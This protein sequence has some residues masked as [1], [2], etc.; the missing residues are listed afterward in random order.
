MSLQ[1]VYANLAGPAQPWIPTR[2]VNYFRTYIAGQCLKL[3]LPLVL[4]ISSKGPMEHF[5]MRQIPGLCS[6]EKTS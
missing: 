5:L 4:P 2:E 3:K 6:V 1:Q